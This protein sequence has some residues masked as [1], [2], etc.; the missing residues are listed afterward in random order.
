MELSIINPRRRRTPPSTLRR[1]GRFPLGIA[2]RAS[3]SVGIYPPRAD[4]AHSRDGLVPCRKPGIRLRNPRWASSRDAYPASARNGRRRNNAID[5]P[6]APFCRK[7]RRSVHICFQPTQKDG[8]CP[9]VSRIGRIGSHA[10]DGQ[11]Y[12]IKKP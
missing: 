9:G 6:R 11:E 1:G 4:W 8:R 2:D 12:R 7:R 10:T 3:R 5:G